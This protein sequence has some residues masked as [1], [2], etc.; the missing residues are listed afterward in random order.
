MRRTKLVDRLLVVVSL[1]PRL[2]P[3]IYNAF[4]LQLTNSRGLVF[5]PSY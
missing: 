4:V 1:V 2:P 5:I 3:N